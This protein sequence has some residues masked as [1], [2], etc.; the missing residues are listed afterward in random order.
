LNND[1]EVV[2]ANWLKEMVACFDYEDV[3]IVGAKLLYPNGKLQ[4][5]G[6]IAGLGQLAG[7]WYI[8]EEAN[9]PGPMGRLW[10]RQTLSCV[11]GAVMLIS[12]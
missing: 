1:I 2:E 10:V 6:V 11:T 8:E 4:H 5:A 12:R 3:G 9:F 7:H